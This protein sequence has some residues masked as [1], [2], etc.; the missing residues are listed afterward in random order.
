MTVI[1]TFPV[2]NGLLHV[3]E[4]T[5]PPLFAFV[6][7]ATLFCQDLKTGE[8][9]AVQSVGR[10]KRV[11]GEHVALSQNEEDVTFLP[12]SHAFDGFELSLVLFLRGVLE[13]LRVHLFHVAREQKSFFAARLI[14]RN[15][16][17][18]IKKN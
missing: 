8:F 5:S 12:D 11:R 3:A 10:Q 2:W 1:A 9:A 6:V 13:F 14:G 4:T 15:P 7:F 18:G 17:A 16:K